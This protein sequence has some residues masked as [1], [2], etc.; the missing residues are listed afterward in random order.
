[1]VTF[2]IINFRFVNILEYYLMDTFTR[3]FHQI[4]LMFY[5]EE[6][7]GGSPQISLHVFKR[8]IRFIHKSQL[9]ANFISLI[10]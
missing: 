7:E 8:R 3:D 1:M 4:G 2:E 5:L 10:Y 9:N 6:R